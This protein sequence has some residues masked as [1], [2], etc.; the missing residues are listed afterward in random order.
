MNHFWKSMA[1]KPGVFLF[2]TLSKIEYIR[3]RNLIFGLE[4]CVIP[5]HHCKLSKVCVGILQI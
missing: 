4:S 1:C 5:E 3:F 2:M